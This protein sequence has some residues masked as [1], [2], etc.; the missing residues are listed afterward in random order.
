[1]PATGLAPRRPPAPARAS[2]VASL[3]I[4]VWLVADVAAFASASYV[5]R[6]EERNMFYLAPF[7]LI[8]LLGLGV[9]GV[10]TRRRKPIVAAAVIAGVLPVFI[11]FGHFLTPS[12][13]SDSSFLRPWGWAQAPPL[14]LQQVRW[15]AFAV[16]VAAAVLFLF[17]PRRYALVLPALVAVYFVLTAIVV[18]SGRHGIHKTTL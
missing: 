13:L 15:A 4:S 12:A 11:P 17:L 8:A 18:E 7:G 9:D 14:H 5:D 2:P 3:A 6:I 10:V 16:S 1:L